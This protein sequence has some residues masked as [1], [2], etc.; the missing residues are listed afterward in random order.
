[1]QRHVAVRRGRD[2]HVAVW[3][4]RDYMMNNL[5]IRANLE[6]RKKSKTESGES[7][8]LGSEGRLGQPFRG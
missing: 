4:E 8:Y 2:G 6:I 1:M 5:G 7:E 3:G